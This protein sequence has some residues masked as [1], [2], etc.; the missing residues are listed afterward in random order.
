MDFNQYQEKAEKT[1]VFPKTEPMYPFLGLGGECGEILELMKKTIRDYDG[2]LTDERRELLKKELGDVLWY[3]SA[4]ATQ[5]GF[6]L[7]D[8]AQTNIDK[9]FSRM[10]RGKLN[11]SGDNR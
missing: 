8:I 5:Y 3:I 4:I 10:E 6:E 2:K 7:D 11:G 9:L 1:V